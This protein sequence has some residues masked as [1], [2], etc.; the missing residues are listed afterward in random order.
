MENENENI[1]SRDII[2]E[3]LFRKY[4]KVLRTY[5]YRLLNDKDMA[6][7]IVQDVYFELWKNREKLTMEETIKYY[8]FRSVYTKT[9][10]YRNS[11]QFTTQEVL[12]HAIEDKIQHIYLQSHTTDQESELIYKEL[13]MTIN[14]AI[15]SLPAQCK[16]V[17]LLSRKHEL[18]NREIAAKLGVS[19]K[20]VEKHI[21][22]ALSILRSNLKD[23]D[24]I[25]LIPLFL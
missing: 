22:K 25:L 7:D 15:G 17:F 11:K 16:K 6:E 5:A 24:L 4:Y 1:H 10:N 8:L 3:D 9:I 14:S 2:V 19:E 20:T 21:T 12:D 18:K 23:V 13:K